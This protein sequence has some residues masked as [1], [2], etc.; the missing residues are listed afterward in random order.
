MFLFLF[1]L[2]LN[3]I[4]LLPTEPVHQ[5]KVVERDGVF[6]L[7]PLLS[8]KNDRLVLTVAIILHALASNGTVTANKKN[9]NRYINTTIR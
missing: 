8:S 2:F 3:F 5:Q 7:V 9:N 4:F 6:T 1:I